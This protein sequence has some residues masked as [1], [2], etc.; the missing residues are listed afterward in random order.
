MLGFIIVI[1]LQC[2]GDTFTKQ[3]IYKEKLSVVRDLTNNV[4]RCCYLTERLTWH[5]AECS[6]VLLILLEQCMEVFRKS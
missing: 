2:R 5:A 1:D 4:V 3:V 6:A